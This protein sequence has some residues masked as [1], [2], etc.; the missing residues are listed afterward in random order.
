MYCARR[1]RSRSK[2]CIVL[3]Q[4]PK[5]YVQHPAVIPYETQRPLRFN[6]PYIHHRR[7]R[8]VDS[9]GSGMISVPY[10]LSLAKA[11]RYVHALTFALHGCFVFFHSLVVI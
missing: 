4:R 1:R 11:R 9:H 3:N 6:D 7:P 2:Q 5:R 8:L 10:L